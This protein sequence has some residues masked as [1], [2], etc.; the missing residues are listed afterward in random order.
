VSFFSL[1]LST[2]KGNLMSKTALTFWSACGRNPTPE[3]KPK[4]SEFR[5]APVG[6]CAA[7]GIQQ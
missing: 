4:A 1:R 6:I 2:R 3:R 5:L 7:G